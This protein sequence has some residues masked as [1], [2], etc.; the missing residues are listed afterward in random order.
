[1]IDWS[2]S[3][4]L[5]PQ[6]AS[7][8]PHG[9][10]GWSEDLDCS[11]LE[12]AYYHG[13]FPWP[14]DNDIV[15]WFS[16]PERGVVRMENFHIPHGT[17][18]EL[19]KK[20]WHLGIDTAFDRVIEEC[21]AAFRPGQG[22][23]WITPKMIRAYK[24]FHRCGRAHSFETYDEHGM[25]LGGLYGIHQGGIFCGESMFFK[26]SCASKFALAGMFQHLK[27]MGVKLVDTQMVTPTLALFGA[28]EISRQE[29]WDLLESLRELEVPWQS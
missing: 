26:E 11:M 28:G 9:F 4:F 10:A 27:S 12:D 21:A 6:P 18:R 25:L 13:V 29:Y 14:E 2:D 8:D 16:P 3:C 24:A 7:E 5:P 15:L 20:N 22:G 19:K 1:M 23:T 17:R